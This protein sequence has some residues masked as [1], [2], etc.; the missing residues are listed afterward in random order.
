M[1]I[2]E[3]IL[4]GSAPA[5]GGSTRPIGKIQAVGLSNALTSPDLNMNSGSLYLN[6]RFSVA[7]AGSPD[8]T[9]DKDNYIAGD[10]FYAPYAD[11]ELE[12]LYHAAKQ[13]GIKFDKNWV[14]NKSE[15]DSVNKT[16]PIK[17]TGPVVLRRK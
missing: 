13:I 1:K 11:E 3:I 6:Y 10:P 17:A 16:S 4:E 9:M 14:S 5:G 12:T 8:Q 7:L 2:N 15:L